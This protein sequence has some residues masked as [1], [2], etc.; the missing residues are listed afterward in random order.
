MTC[1]PKLPTI[2]QSL[3]TVATSL[4]CSSSFSVSKRLPDSYS[5]GYEHLF[6]EEIPR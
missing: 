5:V 2:L 1:A 4:R 6:F 3:N